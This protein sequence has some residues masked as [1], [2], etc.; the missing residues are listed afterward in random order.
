MRH[1]CKDRIA[2]GIGKSVGASGNCLYPSAHLQISA[3]HGVCV[4]WSVECSAAGNC[5]TACAVIGAATG[6]A[7]DGLSA[8]SLCCWAEG[9][10][11]DKVRGA[12]GWGSGCFMAGKYDG[13]CAQG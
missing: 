5:Y 2:H 13:V 1:R 10:C 11:Q 4:W 9:L 12:L 3:L 7:Q 8:V 6:P